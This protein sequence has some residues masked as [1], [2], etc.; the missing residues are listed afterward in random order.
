MKSTAK[1]ARVIKGQVP[2][3]IQ[4]EK[5]N[6]LIDLLNSLLN[7]KTNPT[8]GHIKV[9]ADSSVLDLQGML[10]TAIGSYAEKYFSSESFEREVERIIEERLANATFTLTCDESGGGGTITVT[11]A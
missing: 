2:T 3:L 4:A 7:L 11:I 1:I 5:A 10:E 6:E 8:G 9:G